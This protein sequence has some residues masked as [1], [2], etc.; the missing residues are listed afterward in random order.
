[1]GETFLVLKFLIPKMISEV[2]NKERR[3]ELELYKLFAVDEAFGIN[4]KGYCVY[5]N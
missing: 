1:M 2:M 5:F 3:K 4:F